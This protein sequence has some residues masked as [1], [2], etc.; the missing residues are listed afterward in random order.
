MKNFL[1]RIGA[2]T[3]LVVFL[4]SCKDTI[5]DIY[6]PEAH[7]KFLPRDGITFSHEGGT[8]T[9]NIVTNQKSWTVVSDKKWFELKPNY[10][11]NTITITAAFNETW[12]PMETA[13]IT[14]TAGAEDDVYTA[15]LTVDQLPKPMCDLSEVGTANCYVVKEPGRYQF[16]VGLQGKSN[17]MTVESLDDFKN[18]Q[19]DWV[20]MTSENML[21]VWPELD[22]NGYA[23]FQTSDTYTP[24]N[25]VIALKKDNK[26]LWTWHIWFTDKIIEDENKP[27]MNMN[28]G[29]TSDQIKSV[30]TLGLYYQWGR[31]DPFIGA[32]GIGDKVNKKFNE[33]IPFDIGTTNGTAY[34][35]QNYVNTNDDELVPYWNSA[36]IT[37]EQLTH[38]EASAIPT[39]FIQLAGKLPS[40]STYIWPEEADPCPLGWR[41]PST[42]ELRNTVSGAVID[43]EG[44][45]GVTLK[46][47][48][49]LPAAG[50]RFAGI[51]RASDDDGALWGV[52]TIGMY[53]AGRQFQGPGFGGMYYFDYQGNYMHN[54][55][56]VSYAV[57]VRCYK[58]SYNPF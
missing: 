27:F 25:A 51:H 58:E 12:E 50:Y 32:G 49:Y 31:K 45:S 16:Y 2:I 34:T 43:V 15:T 24:G 11:D 37:G 36:N 20:W 19:M 48:Y 5:T 4:S 30:E 55:Y 7:A 41:L 17:L 39:T 26:I 28:L 53:W 38:V 33:V 42:E 1:L 21:D 3:L 56:L 35:A 40:Y 23:T 18:C 13:T 14:L 52:G 44:I 9:I 54:G 10:D 47:G 6:H 22:E 46:T 8:R 57:P 29:A